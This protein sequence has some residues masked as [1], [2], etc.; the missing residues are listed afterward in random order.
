[1]WNLNVESS[2]PRNATV[3][4]SAFLLQMRLVE[5]TLWNCKAKHFFF[6][7]RSVLEQHCSKTG[8]QS[9]LHSLSLLKTLSTIGRWHEGQL[10]TCGIE[11]VFYI[12]KRQLKERYQR[13]TR[14]LHNLW[15][16]ILCFKILNPLSVKSVKWFLGWRSFHKESRFWKSASSRPYLFLMLISYHARNCVSKHGSKQQ[17]V[18]VHMCFCSLSHLDNVFSECEINCR[19]PG[20]LG[21]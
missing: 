5:K 18:Q 1:M 2:L 3:H 11:S 10:G 19:G 12:L 9:V 13:W 15:F 21:G 6:T 8:K 17:P 16:H 14:L 4:S 7:L 20:V